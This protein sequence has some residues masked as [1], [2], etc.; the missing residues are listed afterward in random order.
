LADRRRTNPS[1]NLRVKATPRLDYERLADALIDRGLLDR[2]AARLVLQQA[3]SAGTPFCEILVD[4]NLVSDWEVAR[5]TAEIFNLPFLPVEVA[6]PS[7]RVLA[8][9]DKDYLRKHGLVPLDRIGDILTVAMPGLVPSAIL[10]AVNTHEGTLVL[11]VVGLV[12]SNRAWL[13]KYAPASEAP[14]AALPVEVVEEADW[15]N[16]FDAGDE[17][18]QLNLEDEPLPPPPPPPLLRQ[19]PQPQTGKP[20]RIVLDESDFS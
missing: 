3:H 16:I 17:A 5:I 7:E 13:T 1:H 8:T 20:R 15:A 18:V 2:E 4:E 9:L 10:N 11:P 19:Q 14:R 12:Q 6:P